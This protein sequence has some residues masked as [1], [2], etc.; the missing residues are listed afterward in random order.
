MN[1]VSSESKA[2]QNPGGL[3][4]MVLFIPLPQQLDLL[5]PEQ[6]SEPSTSEKSVVVLVWRGFGER[7]FS[8]KRIL[9]IYIYIY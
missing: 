5:F 9:N 7:N 6:V 2:V 8:P 1:C 3:I 4:A